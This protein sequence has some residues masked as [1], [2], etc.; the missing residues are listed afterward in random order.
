MCDHYHP[1]ITDAEPNVRILGLLQTCSQIYNEAVAIP[2]N[3]NVLRF[4]RIKDLF[5]FMTDMSV[6][7]VSA[8][9]QVSIMVMSEDIEYRRGDWHHW[10][11]LQYIP[12]LRGLLIHDVC[13]SSER[14]LADPEHAICRAVKRLKGLKMLEVRAS[15]FEPILSV[16]E[17]AR[18]LELAWKE[19]IA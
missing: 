10:E 3:R 16:I 15:T 9:R 17:D 7:R 11:M 12:D 18:R 8:V 19:A 6:E 14:L 2:Y 13:F 5:E 1:G 4:P